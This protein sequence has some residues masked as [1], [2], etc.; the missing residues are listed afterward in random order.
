MR[1]WTSDLAIALIFTTDFS[2]NNQFS[3]RLYSTSACGAGKEIPA[4]PDA[5][6]RQVSPPGAT[7]HVVSR[8]PGAA[9]R[10]DIEAGC[11]LSSFIVHEILRSSAVQARQVTCCEG[12]RREPGL[13]NLDHHRCNRSSLLRARIYFRRSVDL[14]WPK[15]GRSSSPGWPRTGILSEAVTLTA[16]QTICL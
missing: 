15:N 7:N 3:A 16:T 9:L 4:I 1:F 10:R 5:F 14:T 2:Q 6:L 12:Q 11:L 13:S 8:K